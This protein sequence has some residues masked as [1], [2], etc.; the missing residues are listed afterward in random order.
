MPS[1]QK[2]WG[3][4]VFAAGFH[5]ALDAGNHLQHDLGFK[6]GAEGSLRYQLIGQLLARMVGLGLQSFRIFDA[7]VACW[8]SFEL[9]H[10]DVAR[11]ADPV[12]A[13]HLPDGQQDDFEIQN[14]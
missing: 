13:D 5:C 11:M 1:G 6:L 2:L 9:L 14:Q 10:R 7:Y 4:T 3:N 8:I 12:P